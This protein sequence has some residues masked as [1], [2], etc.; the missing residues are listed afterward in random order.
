MVRKNTGV[1]VGSKIPRLL[2]SS[3][4]KAVEGGNYLNL[5]DFIRSAIKEKLLQEGHALYRGV[6]E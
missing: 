4:E 5:S 6:T 1:Y 3:M 2:R